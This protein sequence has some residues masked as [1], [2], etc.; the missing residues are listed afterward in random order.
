MTD[1]EVI[2][3]LTTAAAYDRRKVGDADVVA[4]RAAIGDLDFPDALDAVV[5]HYTESTEWLMPAHVRTRVKAIRSARL[6]KEI[7]P[8]PP[9]GMADNVIDYREALQRSLKRLASGWSIG[10]ALESGKGDEPNDEYLGIRGE[11]REQRNARLAAMTV[12]CPRCRA[13]VNKRCVN[14]VGLPLVAAPAHDA[15]LVAAGVARWVEVNGQRRAEMLSG[16]AGDTS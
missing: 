7:P 11:G 9:A 8:A 1:D 4:W 2:D 3:L 12:K 5:G 14:A 16:R 15:R 13:R 10:L 6:A